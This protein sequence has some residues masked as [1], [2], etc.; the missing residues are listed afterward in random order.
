MVYATRLLLLLLA[1]P[2]LGATISSPACGRGT[3][4]GVVRAREEMRPV[5][6][7]RVRPLGTMLSTVTG[8][9]GRYR[10]E[11]VPPGE[12]SVLVS[13]SGYLPRTLSVAVQAGD[14]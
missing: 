1:L 10:L 9:D 7:A 13:A 8:P 4:V 11:S 12:R 6:D 3:V 2:P 14:S 5:P